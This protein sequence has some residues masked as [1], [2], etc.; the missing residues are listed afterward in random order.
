M[1]ANFLISD[2]AHEPRSAGKLRRA[3]IC[4]QVLS[5]AAGFKMLLLMLSLFMVDQ[6]GM[7]ATVY[8]GSGTEARAE[9]S[10]TEFI[11]PEKTLPTIGR[12]GISPAWSPDAKY[13]AYMS[14][15]AGTLAVLDV[16]TGVN[17]SIDAF[18]I[19]GV[20]SITWSH[21]GEFLALTNGMDIFIASI[22]Q[23]R[24]VKHFVRPGD[25]GLEPSLAFLKGGALLAQ[26][27]PGFG[28]HEKLVL[29]LDLQGSVRTLVKVPTVDNEA[30]AV[31]GGAFKW[32]SG[33]LYFT[34]LT[35]YKVGT[36]ASEL[37]AQDKWRELVA[38]K[39]KNSRTRCYIYDLGAAPQEQSDKQIRY[40]D[41]ANYFPMGIDGSGFI[42]N[43][44]SCTLGATAEQLVVQRNNAAAI[45]GV[46][47]DVSKDKEFEVYDVASGRRLAYFG[48]WSGPETKWL[49]EW[50]I[51]PLLPWLI[52][53]TRHAD[54][55][56]PR[57]RGL[58]TIWNLTKGEVIDRHVAPAGCAW[59]RISPD[60]RKLAY[61]ADGGIG[62]AAIH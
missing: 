24:F 14:W 1:G 49:G 30:V 53:P 28:N 15:P 48:G 36:V 25:C 22:Q 8:K 45:P 19:G 2:M 34:V 55:P 58:L 60:G 42:R 10:G 50:D 46:Q 32:I 40:L 52:A 59:V 29:E 9:A 23:R 35:Y 47:T 16:D 31:N 3:T 57:D 41:L 11:R 4:R 18:A 39:Q 13:L 5:E 62:I 38:T 54:A 51:A 17:T 44:S 12:G 61:D 33:H 26:C 37:Y 6:S 43:V 20:Q 21:D 56:G 27:G 7:C